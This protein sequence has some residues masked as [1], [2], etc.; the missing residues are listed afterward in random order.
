MLMR[1]PPRCQERKEERKPEENGSRLV[2]DRVADVFGNDGSR[3][4]P[5]LV[6]GDAVE[7]I[8]DDRPSSTD[9]SLRP[10]SLRR[11]RSLSGSARRAIVIPCSASPSIPVSS[12]P[13]S[14]HPAIGGFPHH[15]VLSSVPQWLVIVE[16]NDKLS[17]L[18]GREWR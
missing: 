6:Q 10:S 11:M 7:L 4:H 15:V 5:V 14:L 9:L 8:E 13:S 12:P 1:K 18:V 2:V 16:Q 17:L 3:P